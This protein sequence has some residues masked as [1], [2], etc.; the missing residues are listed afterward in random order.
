MTV[1]SF[2]VRAVT[3]DGHQL[4][5]CA[6]ISTG[7]AAAL[8]CVKRGMGAFPD[9]TRFFVRGGA[10]HRPHDYAGEQLTGFWLDEAGSIT[11]EQIDAVRHWGQIERFDE[12]PK[13]A[14]D[15]YRAGNRAIAVI[16]ILIAGMA[17][18]QALRWLLS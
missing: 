6:A 16:I 14:F 11:P 10:P 4:V 15:E 3:A 13:D 9:G 17:A 5:N 2:S 18:M 8:A 7:P 1:G 12:D